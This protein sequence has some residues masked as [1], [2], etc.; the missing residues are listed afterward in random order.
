MRWL[1]LMAA[2]AGCATVGSSFRRTHADRNELVWAYHGGLL[3][4]R[5][6]QVV[7]AQD[8]WD[9]L[10]VAVSCVPRARD[11]AETAQSRKRRGKV[12]VWSGIG[13]MVAAAVAGSVL[14]YKD[15]HN[16]DDIGLGLLT[17]TG[18]LSGGLTMT[19]TGSFMRSRAD[20]TAIDA[21]NMFNDDRATCTGG[22]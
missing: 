17:L 2:L 14:I 4:T 19:L 5:G 22:T 3:V 20:V 16:L 18:G 1:A 21:V 7:A 6:G 11:Q 13:L 9:G 12:L 8:T 10:P 15:R